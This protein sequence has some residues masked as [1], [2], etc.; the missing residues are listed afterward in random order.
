ML[1][2]FLFCLIVFSTQTEFAHEEASLLKAF[3]EEVGYLRLLM[4][5]NV[6]RLLAKV[7]KP[8]LTMEER[9]KL[10]A[11]KRYSPAAFVTEYCE[12]GSLHEVLRTRLAAPHADEKKG[13]ESPTLTDARKWSILLDLATA[14]LYLHKQK[15]VHRD[16]KSHNVF[17]TRTW[18]AKIGDF[19]LA[20]TQRQTAGM[21]SHEFRLLIQSAGFLSKSK[22]SGAGT[23]NFMAP[24][25]CNPDGDVG[26]QADIYGFGGVI[27]D[28]IA[29]Q[30][31]LFMIN[32]SC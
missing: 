26:V 22:S 25:Q 15:I 8:T 6:V 19:G 27:T 2:F 9:Q 1:S 24:E 7:K 10:E 11:T 5:S 31:A 13:M 12:R 29:G 32:V 16:I 14:L 28:L 4:H 17:L 21:L 3:E 23:M 18:Q 30:H 20:R